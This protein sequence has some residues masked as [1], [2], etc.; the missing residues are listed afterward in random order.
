MLPVSFHAS[1]ST[2]HSK[3]WH[4]PSVA[5]QKIKL[6]HIFAYLQKGIWATDVKEKWEE[7]DFLHALQ[8]KSLN[9]E[10]KAEIQCVETPGNTM[11]IIRSKLQ[12]KVSENSFFCIFTIENKL[13]RFNSG[14]QTKLT[15]HV[16]VFAWIICT[17]QKRTIS[18]LTSRP[19]SP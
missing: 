13:H 3:C 9:V 17:V 4:N 15:C 11:P 12:T 10:N 7:V 5:L 16:D 2:C 1:F 19:V 6:D 14:F 18:R 8:V